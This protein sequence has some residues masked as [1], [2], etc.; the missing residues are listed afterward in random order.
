MNDEFETRVETWLRERARPDPESLEAVRG[1]IDTL[2]PRRRRPQR[3]WLAGVAA[4]IAVLAIGAS[5]LLLSWPPSGTAPSLPSVPGPPDPAAFAGDPRLRACYEAAGPVEFAFEMPHARDYQRH[6]PAMLLA[7][8][9]DV[10]D[11]AFAVVFASDAPPVVGGSAPSSATS[12]PNGS[13]NPNDRWVCIL[14]GDTPNVYSNVDISGMRVDLGETT[15]ASPTAS[16]TASPASPSST[17]TLTPEPPPSA[18]VEAPWR[19]SNLVPSPT[20]RSSVG[21]AH[22]GW[23]ST[24]WL[25]IDDKELYLRDPDGIFADVEVGAFLPDTAL[26]NEARDAGLSSQGRRLFTVPRGD[27]VY[28]ETPTGVERWPRSTDPF[29]GCA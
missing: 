13:S 6:F 12:D 4:V 15:A 17:P 24:V 22:C 7:P 16:P 27:A 9:L 1:S 25:F 11:P 21:P 20:V 26:P 3:A 29:I 23:E 14:V 28:V 10:D 18:A 8:E 2:S 19:D 5:A